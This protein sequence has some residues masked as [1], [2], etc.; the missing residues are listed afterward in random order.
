MSP[1]NPCS[2]S[3]TLLRR[4]GFLVLPCA[5]MIALLWLPFGFSITGLIEE[6]DVLALFTLREPF[7]WVSPDGPLG[8]HRLR[9]LTV[10]PHA[11][12]YLL[13]P[14][15][16]GYWH[17]LLIA[18]LFLKGVGASLIGWWLTH[19]R[20]WSVVLGLLVV[21]YPAD[22]MQLSFR[23]FHIDWSISLSLLGVALCAYAYTLQKPWQR[24]L[25]MLVAVPCAVLATFAYE[26]A[27][28]FVVVPLLLL[29]ARFG[30]RGGLELVKRRPV[31]S[32]AWIFGIVVNIGYVLYAKGTGDTYQGALMG[33][34]MQIDVLDRLQRVGGIGFGRS[35]LGA[36]LDAAAITWY[37]YRTHLYLVLSTAL[38]A[39]AV[40]R[41]SRAIAGEDATADIVAPT[42]S[43]A[44][45]AISGLVLIGLGYLPFAASLPHLQISQ[46]TF[47]GAAPGAAL[48][49]VS[50][51][52]AFTRRSW[53]LGAALTTAALVVAFAAQMFQFDHYRRLS[54]QQQTLLAD[55]VGNVPPFKL[56]QTLVIIDKRDQINDVWMVREG[57]VMALTYLY[58]RP[59]E[60]PVICSGSDNTWQFP[61]AEGRLGTCA[62]TEQGWTMTEAPLV[63]APD[64]APKTVHVKR[65]NAVVV[66]LEADGSTTSTTPPE[67]LSEY[68]RVLETGHSNLA[69]RYRRVLRPTAWPLSF[70][71]FRTTGGSDRFRW[72]FGRWWSMEEPTR[73]AGWVTGGWTIRNKVPVWHSVAWKIKPEATLQFDLLPG[74]GP[75]VFTARILQLVPPTTPESIKLRVNGQLV[76]VQWKDATTLSAAVPND[77]LRIGTNVVTFESPLTNDP[78]PLSFLVDWVDLRPESATP[79]GK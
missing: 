6:W 68:R 22:T 40:W 32:A 23:S 21:F 11:I 10:A 30:I 52:I 38:V 43:L 5:V 55:I 79:A 24:A 39:L 47:L 15:S 36:W 56:D 44:R 33:P 14:N 64:A 76:A 70:D 48:V 42:S 1:N 3:A 61:N 16:F 31:V 26:A 65:E 51:L 73:G 7:V 9:P 59:I 77:A 54:S 45:I 50:V 67:V 78:T 74:P 13:D 57:M 19:S 27:L 4:W 46:R 66:T 8:A 49:C 2:P 25:A 62:E 72:D 34:S 63:S 35:L 71:Q 60:R 18:S 75:Y 28:T 53:G 29:Y 69:E 12:G 41:S 20:R 37:E 17:V 58:D